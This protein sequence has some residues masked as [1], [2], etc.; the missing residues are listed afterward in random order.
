MVKSRA[1]AQSIVDKYKSDRVS[2][3]AS[4]GEHSDHEEGDEADAPVVNEDAFE[5]LVAFREFLVGSEAFKILHAQVEAFVIPKPPHPATVEAISETEQ[6]S[7]KPSLTRVV[8]WDRSTAKTCQ[9]WLMDVR[10][11]VDAIFGDRDMVSFMAISI[12][13][14]IDALF[15]ITDDLLITLGHLEPPLREGMVRLRWQCVRAP[16][17]SKVPSCKCLEWGC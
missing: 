8:E 9:D 14:A 1:L 17:L 4:R 10:R 15:L 16:T 11:N 12:Y 13:L 6:N 5:D 2:P 7:T 3:Q